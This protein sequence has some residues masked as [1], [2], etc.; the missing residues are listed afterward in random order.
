MP[1]SSANSVIQII[2]RITG[3]IF[4]LVVWWHIFF[5]RREGAPFDLHIHIGDV[6]ELVGLLNRGLYAYAEIDNLSFAGL[7]EAG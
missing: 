1:H 3:N 5:Q 7:D 4:F 2:N 6:S